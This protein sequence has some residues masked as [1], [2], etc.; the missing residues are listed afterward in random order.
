MI[1]SHPTMLRI[2]LK[3]VALDFSCE[4]DEDEISYIEQQAFVG[5]R[6]TLQLELVFEREV[7]ARRPQA[8]AAGPG[9]MI[10]TS[11]G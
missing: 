2:K 10:Q 9:T 6:K 7:K 8:H 11:L 3:S 1:V 4:S 5:I